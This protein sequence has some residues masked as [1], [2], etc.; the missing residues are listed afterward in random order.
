MR[1]SRDLNR[2]LATHGRDGTDDLTGGDVDGEPRAPQ[3]PIAPAS[4]RRARPRPAAGGDRG[5]QCDVGR[6]DSPAEAADAGTGG[7]PG[8]GRI[9]L[10]E[11]DLEPRTPLDSI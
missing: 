5:L 7:D 2:S 3:G 8:D 6:R 9:S 11:L 10:A 1:R 4:N